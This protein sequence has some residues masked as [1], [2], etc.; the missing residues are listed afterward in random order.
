MQHP[1][2]QQFFG[3]ETEQINQQIPEYIVYNEIVM[4]I[5]NNWEFA[6]NLMNKYKAGQLKQIGPLEQ[7]WYNFIISNNIDILN[8]KNETEFLNTLW[9]IPQN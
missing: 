6:N 5:S 8:F 3:N 4:E 7:T 1:F 2:F 9:K